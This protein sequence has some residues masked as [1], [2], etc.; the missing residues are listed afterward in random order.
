MG[1]TLHTSSIWLHHC[2]C[3][4]IQYTPCQ[5]VLLGHQNLQVLAQQILANGSE[6]RKLFLDTFRER[7]VSSRVLL[8]YIPFQL[9]RFD[10][11]VCVVPGKTDPRGAKAESLDFSSCFHYLFQTWLSK[12][13]LGGSYGHKIDDAEPF[14]HHFTGELDKFEATPITHKLVYKIVWIGIRRPSKACCQTTCYGTIGYA[15]SRRFGD[16]KSSP[17]Q[18]CLSSRLYCYPGAIHPWLCLKKGQQSVNDCNQ[19]RHWGMP[20]V[21][22]PVEKRQDS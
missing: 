18:M 20:Q 21:V 16:L 22:I 6:I 7:W 4:L 19:L 10:K 5:L 1:A 3:F 11:R 13:A 15:G 12:P 17:I 14:H 8:V 9:F 2:A